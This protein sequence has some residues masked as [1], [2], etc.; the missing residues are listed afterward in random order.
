MSHRWKVV[1]AVSVGNSLSLLDLFVVNVAFPDIARDFPGTSLA[2]L[3]WILNAYTIPLAALL[4]PGGRLA[5]LVGRKRIYLVGL[6]AF[7]VASVLCA[8]APSVGA[9][10]AARALQSTGAAL[11]VP[12][13]L[14]LILA[15]LPV[16][17][18]TK[19]IA[20]WASV[21]AL[22]AAV[23]PTVGGL[24]AEISWRWIFLINLPIGLAMLVYARSLLRE[25]RDPAGRRPDIIGAACLVLGIGALTLSIVQGPDWGWR[26]ARVIAGFAVAGALVPLVLVRSARHPAPVVELSIL[27]VPSFAIGSA[28]T[29]LFFA[30]FGPFLLGTVLFL[31]GVWHYSVLD[32]ALALA[33]APLTFALASAVSG[34]M[35]PGSAQR[36]VGAAGGLIFAVGGLWW[37]WGVGTEPS[38]AAEALPGMILAGIG[39]GLAVPVVMGVPAIALPPDRFATGAAVVTM[40]R[41]VG[42]AVGVAILI[43]ILGGAGATISLTAFEHAWE[44][45]ALT[46]AAAGVSCLVLTIASSSTNATRS[47]S[48]RSARSSP[49]R[50]SPSSISA[51]KELNRPRSS[52]SARSRE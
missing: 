3:S 46:A 15:E 44:F 32:A 45:V 25:S 4:V 11:L 14:A 17:E 26:S 29:L 34:R 13:A 12:S 40:F 19:G 33:P 24:L 21:A 51:K 9:L 27:R 23:G 43:A 28:G 20:V 48:T 36:L 39:G 6:G 41:Q 42:A 2:D 5:D 50:Y 37:A 18:R 35:S 30:A 22:A 7:T 10:T 8:L 49:A 47:G 52:S 38:Y 31:T 1:A 16:A